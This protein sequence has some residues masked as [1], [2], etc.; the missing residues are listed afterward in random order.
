MAASQCG[1]HKNVF[2]SSFFCVLCI[3]KV[4]FLAQAFIKTFTT[5]L[6]NPIYPVYEGKSA[7]LS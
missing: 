4:R 1:R 2:L 3:G 7:W 6:A 5:T